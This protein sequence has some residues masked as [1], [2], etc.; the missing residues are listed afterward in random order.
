[1]PPR[2]QI[3]R[4]RAHPAR[5]MTWAAFPVLAWAAILW[6]PP[7]V[8]AFDVVSAGEEIT[9][10][11]SRVFS[12]YARKRLADG[13]FQPERYGFAIGGFLNRNALGLEMSATI[14]TRDDT[15][16][17]LGFAQIARMIEGPLAAQKF[18]P[19]HNPGT[20]DLVIVVFWGRSIGT[21]AHPGS[22]MS[23][24]LYGP[25]Q[26]RIDLQNAHLMG[27]DSEGVFG[28][29]FLGNSIASAMKKQLHS[30]VM[31]AIK[32]DRY[33]VILRAFDFQ[34]AWKKRKLRLLWETRFSLSQRHHDFEKDLPGMAQAASPY[35]GQD[36]GGLV[37]KPIPLG[38]VDIGDVRSLGTEPEK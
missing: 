36:S 32:E 29:G 24:T 22:M 21:S 17:E 7:V 18:L 11:S 13:S 9:A 12:G 14:F 23:D 15:I 33:Y 2:L 8:R 30:G 10:V 34:S 6:A 31:A 38:R 1:M 26:D 4:A 37:R 19:T 16:D 28:Q 5:S 27:F 3:K 35:F 25:D 20:A